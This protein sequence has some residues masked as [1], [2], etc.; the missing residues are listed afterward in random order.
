MAEKIQVA[1]ISQSTVSYQR[2][3]EYVQDCQEFLAADSSTH[4]NMVVGDLESS[5]SSFLE[6]NQF[7]Q[8]ILA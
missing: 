4:P 5:L 8:Q 1:D 2:T 7:L 6:E 3:L